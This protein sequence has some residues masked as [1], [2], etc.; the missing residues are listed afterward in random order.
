MS[1]KKEELLFCPL[2]GSGEIG[3]NMNL[4]SY[5]KPEAQKWIIVDI[6]V[7]FADD[8]IPGIDLI[9]P[10]PGFII[11]KKKDLL[12]IVLT[13]AHEDH[14]GAI[15]HIWPK[16]KC[17]MYATPFTAALIKEKFKEKKIDI[18]KNLKIVDL[19]G[20]I[21]LGPFKIEFITLTHSILE[22]NGLLIETPAGIVLHTGDWKVDPNPLIGNKIDQTKLKEIG[23]KGVL[24]MICDSTNVF[25]HGRAG[26]EA[27]VRTNLLKLM[28][29]LKKR[30]IV[31]SF[32]SN[33]ARMET[34]FYCAE[35]TK[36]QI[37]LVGRSMHRIYKAAKQCGYLKNVISPI[38]A[39]EA[40]KISREKIV[41]LCTGS[42]GEPMGAMMRIINYTH[43]DVFIEKEDTVIFSSKIIPGNEKKLYKLHN[44]L[45][46]NQIDVI[47]E[48]TDFVHVSGH[49][50]REDLR[51]MYD[52]VKPK[53]VIPV[54]GEHRHMAEHISFAKEMQVPYPVQV[55]NGDIVKLF[56]GQKPEVFDK[57]PVGRLYVDGIISVNEDSQSIRERKNLANNGYLEVTILI[58]GKGKLFKK[59]LVSFKGLPIEEAQDFFYDLEDEIEN[60]SR[61]FSLNNKKQESNLIEALKISCRKIVK[62]KTGKKPY[63]N[64][65]LVRI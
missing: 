54:H 3:M 7:T 65:N 6:G 22:P 48:E 16:L 40:K 49:P 64:I 33:V 24:A 39:R 61:T 23:N 15:A 1:N 60:I 44:Q 42:Q 10:D 59:P 4:F 37:S 47:S 28:S 36:R 11:D 27:D 35:K 62:E 38:D 19:N 31:T 13:H 41:Y 32:A 57:A 29:N 8:S 53:S 14:I 63:T 51:D 58:N 9:Y 56:P 50:N 25:S 5:G 45:I 2:G 30:I 34:I 52:W 46:K 20:N 17:K 12:G 21:K 43:P 26:S 18:G 55:E